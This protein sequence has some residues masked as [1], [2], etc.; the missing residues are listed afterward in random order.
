MGQTQQLMKEI[1]E[2]HKQSYDENNMRDFIDVYLREMKDGEAPEF[3]GKNT[4]F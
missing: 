4:K 1:V 3:T 2:E